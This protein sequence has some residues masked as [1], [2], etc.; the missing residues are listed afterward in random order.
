MTLV[1]QGIETELLMMEEDRNVQQLGALKDL[2][3]TPLQMTFTSAI[4]AR[5]HSEVS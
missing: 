1:Q 2:S 3:E 5:R 4:R